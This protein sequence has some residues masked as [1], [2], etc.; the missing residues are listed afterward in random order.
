MAGYCGF[1]K[2]NNAVAAEEDGRF[3]ASTLAKRLGVKTGAI[4]ALM[5]SY[6]WHHTSSRYNKTDYYDEQEAL[7]MIDALRAW[8]QPAKDEATYSGCKVTWLEWGGTRKHPRACEMTTENATVTIKGEW[9]TFEHRGRA[10]R[11]K[12]TTRGFQV[13]ASDG[14]SVVR[15]F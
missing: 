5:D 15:S 10:I 1:S 9:A 7:E 14:K 2:S 11:K 8:K 4:K 3:P 13:V 12:I 6:E